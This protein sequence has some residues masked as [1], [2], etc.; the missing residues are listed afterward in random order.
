MSF[1]PPANHQRQSTEEKTMAPNHVAWPHY[2]FLVNG[3][4]SS[5]TSQLLEI[6][7]GQVTRRPLNFHITVG[8]SFIIQVS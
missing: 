4:D 3:Q 6:G 5:L 2:F 1:V 8:L 7:N